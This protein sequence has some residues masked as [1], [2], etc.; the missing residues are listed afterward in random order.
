MVTSDD[1]LAGVI[2]NYASV[3][4]ETPIP[5]PSVK[6]TSTTRPT[7]VPTPT[8]TD[9]PDPDTT[10]KPEDIIRK[11]DVTK[12]APSLSK[13]H[14]VEI[15]EV[16]DYEIVVHNGGNVPY[17]NVIVKDTLDGASIQTNDRYTINTDGNAVIAKL[18]VGES[19]T[20]YADYTVTA[21]DLANG[22][23]VNTAIATADDPDP[24]HKPDE[25]Q[26]TGK[27]TDERD[28]ANPELS[29]VKTAIDTGSYVQPGDEFAYEITVSNK[30]DG[31]AT[32]VVVVD[33][34][35]EQVEYISH[36][37]NGKV[38]VAD[39][40]VTWTI[41]TIR[42]GESITLTINVKVKSQDDLELLDKTITNTATIV[43]Q[44][45]N[46]PKPE[47]KPKDEEETKIAMLE[48]EKT[49]V[50]LGAEDEAS[51]T[52]DLNDVIHYTVKVTNTGAVELT[53]IEVY[54]DMFAK[55]ENLQVAP[56]GAAQFNADDACMII[57]S[58]AV[59]G[60]VVITYEHTVTEDD[61]Y[62]G[63]VFN[64]VS[65][66]T[67]EKSFGS[68]EK[69]TETEDPRPNLMTEK[70]VL[71]WKE[72]FKI[73]DAIQY[74][75]VVTNTGNV[76]A[77]SVVVT[78]T[79][80]SD[81]NPEGLVQTFPI[82]SI[83]PGESKTIEYTYTVQAAD[84]LPAYEEDGTE[85]VHTIYNDAVAM[86]ED[87]NGEEYT[88][89]KTGTVVDVKQYVL[90][91]FFDSITGGLIK[92]AYVPYGGSTSAPDVPEHAGFSFVGWIGGVWT[93]VYSNQIIWASYDRLEGNLNTTILDAE[94][95]L[96]G[97][98]ISNVG[99]CFD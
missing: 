16:I 76:T 13:D 92:E 66:A 73:G 82:D 99:E 31:K 33:A 93:N 88:G 83:A 60:Q 14:K 21:A 59:D 8:P 51:A 94:I 28:T 43:D 25:D 47:D 39:N 56:D 18:E 74:Q 30:G 98:Y 36:A 86:G 64:K 79:L 80:V 85:R 45:V 27:D 40:T 57:D 91:R 87:R 20:V 34:L 77:Y 26:P 61:L 68:D 32:N 54:D 63:K 89:E 29:I 4:G 7:P 44:P 41:D 67:D 11:L 95:P 10:D 19:V 72:S 6:P 50:V 65:V 55:A 46:P 38:D 75:L 2:E 35:P 23:V 53:D 49:A 17:Y 81:A 90:V 24:E 71:N 69:E 9:N 15:D 3:T 42:V 96:A 48:V 62:D 52:A 84:L 70:S 12:T 97:G 1:I 37:G 22:E 78:D 58:L 5:N